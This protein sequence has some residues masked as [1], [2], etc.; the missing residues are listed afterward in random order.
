MPSDRSSVELPE[1]LQRS[2]ASPEVSSV[3]L[4]P[5]RPLGVSILSI[6]H[7]IGGVG[8]LLLIPL[9]L[10]QFDGLKQE[11]Q[12]AG[13]SAFAN[14]LGTAFIA[15]LSLATGV[16]LWK[17]TRWGWWVGAFYYAYAIA[18]NLSA[19]IMTSDMADEFADERR[20]IAYYLVKHSV[21]IAIHFLILLYFFKGNV[22]EYF[23]VSD[24]SKREALIKLI[25]ICGGLTMFA[26]LLSLLTE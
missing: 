25:S 18:R 6:L 1:F 19:L 10:S 17:G 5:N 7:F 4:R 13:I 22:R 9:M 2:A 12:G 21:R 24:V 8:L 16:G 14:L 20:G 15:V 23:G 3:N 26:S 11:G